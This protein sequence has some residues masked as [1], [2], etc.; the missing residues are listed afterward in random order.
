MANQFGSN[1]TGTNVDST[2]EG[3]S[4][5]GVQLDAPM[6]DGFEAGFNATGEDMSGLAPRAPFPVGLELPGEPIGVDQAGIMVGMSPVDGFPT[7]TAFGVEDG[8]ESSV[9]GEA[10]VAGSAG[11]HLVTSFD[12][13]FGGYSGTTPAPLGEQDTN[14]TDGG[15]R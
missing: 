1:T 5:V 10:D 12:Q 11:F 14:S 9:P 13:M 8:N 15:Y 4:V 7:F 2:S 6:R 3:E